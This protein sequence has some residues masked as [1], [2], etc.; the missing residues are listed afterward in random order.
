MQEQPEGEVCEAQGARE[1]LKGIFSFFF[2]SFLLFCFFLS[3][4]LFLRWEEGR[5]RKARTDSL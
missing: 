5:R 4:L 1:A 3:P 2:L